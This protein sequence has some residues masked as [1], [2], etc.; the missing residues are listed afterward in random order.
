MLRI[1]GGSPKRRKGDIDEFDFAVR[2]I[3]SP[4]I[5]ACLEMRFKQT[6]EEY[7][8]EMPD[9]KF[10]KFH[11]YLSKQKQGERIVDYIMVE[12]GIKGPV[13]APPG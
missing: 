10:H 2:A 8:D 9:P 4:C 11:A 6:F 1:R 12:L 5:R 7:V 13:E 3:D